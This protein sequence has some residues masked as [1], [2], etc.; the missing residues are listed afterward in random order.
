MTDEPQLGGEV[1]LK[2]TLDQML[3]MTSDV[4]TALNDFLEDFGKNG[5]LMVVG[6]NVGIVRKILV[7]SIRLAG[8][9]ELPSKAMT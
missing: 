3:C 6:D 2:I 5:I 9:N 1:I 7:V 4:V 8:V